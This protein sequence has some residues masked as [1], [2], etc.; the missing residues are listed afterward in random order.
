[1]KLFIS[2][3][4]VILFHPAF[5]Q[6]PIDVQ[7]Y[8]YEIELSDLSDVITG[9]ATI[10]IKFLQPASLFTL[11]LVSLKEEKGM[12]VFQVKENG[13]SLVFV[14]RANELEIRLNK[15][16]GANEMR[17]F[18]ISYMGIPEDGL[19]ISQNMYGER[20]FFSDNWPDRAHN[21]IP[22]NDVPWDKSSVEFHVKAPSHY[23]IISNGILQEEKIVDANSKLT[24][25]KEDIALPTKIMVIGAA[26]FAVT[27][28]DKNFKI[29]VTAWTYQQDSLKGVKDYSLA[30][31]VIR[32]FEELVGPFP[33]KKLANVQSKTIFGGM[34]NANAIFYA[35]NTVTGTGSSEAL[36]AHEIAHQWFG[37]SVTEK[38]FS[39]LWLSEGF[40]TYLTHMYIEHKYG[41]DSFQKRLII[42]RNKVIAFVKE[43]P[44]SVV[45][46]SQDFMS[47]LNENSYQ[48]GG[49]ILHM[50]REEVGDMHF[51]NILKTFYKEYAFSNADTRDFQSVAERVSG[52]D[53]AWFFNQWLYMPGVPELEIK[54]KVENDGFKIKIHQD[55]T[56]FRVPLK[57]SI[58][59]EDG[60]L[61][62]ERIMVEG[63]ETEYKLKTKGR[64][65]LT[66]D[67]DKQLLFFEVK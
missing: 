50:L 9:K 4:L 20:T 30:Q 17:S 7:H 65:K 36:I 67:P 16:A 56:N 35:E 37:N 62:H 46:S 18:E 39:H 10:R 66:I 32:F 51:K 63:K 3:L 12:K 19:I 8:K 27:R 14:H 22:A 11:D 2:L 55:K 24:I 23:D 42:D 49:W 60:E 6:R 33:Y 45:D 26:R 41:R 52:K 54:S 15:S 28:V 38:N 57:F 43:N 40:A 59:R 53:L 13:E 25:W 31:P 21:W 44:V 48:K 64:V 29:P 5:C 61:M 34:E 58:T 1:M 47:L